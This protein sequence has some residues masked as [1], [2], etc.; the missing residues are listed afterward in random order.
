MGMNHPDIAFG[1]GIYSFADA[2]RFVD[3][4]AAEL[5]RWARGYAYKGRDGVVAQ[6]SAVLAAPQLLSSGLDGVG[7]R[8]LLELRF[9][10]AFRDHGVSMHAVRLA[11]QN[12]KEVL[13]S[14][15]PFTNRQFK[16]DGRSI[17][18]SVYNESGDESLVDIVKKQNV[19]KTI[20]S[21]AL[22]AGIEFD[23]SE[24][25]L[26]WYPLQR[27]RSVVLDPS[28]AFGQ[29]IVS[30]AG[31]PTATLAEMLRAEDGDVD[32][33]ARIFDVSRDAVLKAQQFEERFTHSQ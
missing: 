24:G 15:H 4:P 27:S 1:V 7:F 6:S 13:R 19:F 17:F 26:R 23:E 18:V 5:R 16:T 9:I 25:A 29:P 31:V 10:K 2:A 12:A 20:I 30:E 14:D 8:D 28:R 33:V 22:Y 3:A 32:R 21:P 11:S